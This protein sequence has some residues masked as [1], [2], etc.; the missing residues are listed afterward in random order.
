MA[1][2]AIMIAIPAINPCGLAEASVVTL[3]TKTAASSRN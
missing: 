2:A 1:Q 3:K